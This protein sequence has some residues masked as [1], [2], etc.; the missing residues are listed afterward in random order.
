MLMCS[1]LGPCPLQAL[2]NCT[3]RFTGGAAAHVRVFQ[4]Q[5]SYWAATPASSAAHARHRH[6][7]GR[8]FVGRT[9]RFDES[10]VLL[11]YWLGVHPAQEMWYT[12]RKR[13]YGTGHP[14]RGDWTAAEIEALQ[15][16]MEVTGDGHWHTTMS[17]LYDRQLEAARARDVAG[18]VEL[19]LQ[20]NQRTLSPAEA[21]AERMLKHQ[22]RAATRHIA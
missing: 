7:A 6:S 10:L 15:A 11:A 9:E 16:A 12:S 2:A 17:G 21:E 19:L 5:W 1:D 3:L 13:V 22:H 20:A 4:P 18:D 14:G 8:F